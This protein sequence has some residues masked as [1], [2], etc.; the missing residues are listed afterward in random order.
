MFLA[1]FARPHSFPA[2]H[3]FAR[4][5]AGATPSLGWSLRFSLFPLFLFYSP[6]FGF[7]AC[8]RFFGFVRVPLLASRCGLSCFPSLRFLR[9][10]LGSLD[11]DTMGSRI[12]RASRCSH[13]SSRT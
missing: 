2:A 13:S 12:V 8:L 9:P 3:F 5:A 7:C 6:S 11:P 4:F 10:S 1:G